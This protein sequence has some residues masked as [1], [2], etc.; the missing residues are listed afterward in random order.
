MGG[1]VEG[2]ANFGSNLAALET[3]LLCR[4]GPLD[5]P[6]IKLLRLV[7]VVIFGLFFAGFFITG[8][9][10]SYYLAQARE[11]RVKTEAVPA[12]RGVMVDRDGRLVATNILVDGKT[13]R[14][15]PDGEV[16]AAVVGYLS[17]GKG[18]GW[19]GKTMPD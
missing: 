9:R 15:Y 1:G 12:P 14:H 18:S 5:E 4:R 17:E 2:L 3:E 13:T 11:N 19:A 10:H 8:L 7:L 6:M 16:V